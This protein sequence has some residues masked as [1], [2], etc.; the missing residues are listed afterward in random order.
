MGRLV[1]GVVS[2]RI[3]RPKTF[4][5]FTLASVPLVASLP[6]LITLVNTHPSVFLVNCFIA[7]SVAVVSI[8]GGV[9]AVIPAYES[10]LFGSKYLASNHGKM[11]LASTTAGTPSFSIPSL[12]RSADHAQLPPVF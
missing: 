5:I 6:V 11:L 7:S 9:Y 4:K 12:R 1:W 3:G 8:M 10:D 2:D